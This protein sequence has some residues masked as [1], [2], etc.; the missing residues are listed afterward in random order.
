MQLQLEDQQ[1]F[2]DLKLLVHTKLV[3][4]SL[5]LLFMVIVYQF[6][7]QWIKKSTISKLKQETHPGLVMETKLC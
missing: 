6:S 5:E 2:Q 1:I 7:I 3:I 4:E